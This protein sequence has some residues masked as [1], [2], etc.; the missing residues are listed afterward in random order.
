MRNK[1]WQRLAWVTLCILAGGFS[2]GCGGSGFEQYTPS[3]TTARATLEAALT[4]WQEGKPHGTLEDHSP[5]ISVGDFRWREGNKLQ[6][7]TILEET[8]GDGPVWFTVTLRFRDPSAE[9]TVKYAVIGKEPLWVFT[10]ED[11]GKLMG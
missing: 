8:P 4:A 6:S 10:E 5:V 1:R 9:I 11:Y 2:S 3:S 7:F